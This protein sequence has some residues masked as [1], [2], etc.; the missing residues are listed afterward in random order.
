MVWLK[1][2]IWLVLLVFAGLMV[3]QM[4]ASESGEVVV[5]STRGTGTAP[6]ETRLWV[7]DYDGRQY[8]RAGQPGS[9]WFLRLNANPRVGVERA[10][11]RAA[12]D[13]VPEP[14]RQTII[15]ELMQQKYGWADTFIGK[16]FGRSDAIPVRLDPIPEVD[17]Y[18]PP[19]PAEEVEI[20]PDAVD[21]A[22]SEMPAPGVSEDTRPN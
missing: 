4:V 16:L 9:G 12:Y 10:G 18:P 1:R 5:L 19:P 3:L 2:V 22:D 17:P 15:N 20:L 21:T 11:R 7:V 8:L 14:D 13:A 6:E